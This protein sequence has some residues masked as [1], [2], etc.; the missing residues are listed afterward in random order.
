MTMEPASTAATLPKQEE[1]DDIMRCCASFNLRRAS[2]TVSQMF[3]EFLQP[4]GLRSTQVVLLLKLARHGPMVMSQ[5]ANELMV[6]PST[7]S[8]NLRPLAR[9]GLLEISSRSGR[10]KAVSLTPKGRDVLAAATPLWKKAQDR[11]LAQV[12]SESWDG[13]LRELNGMV[14]TLRSG[15]D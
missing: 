15:Q 14:S 3:D 11:F 10:N 4:S 8:R 12:G 9:D 13:F 7:L 6:S 5:L 1:L 2:R